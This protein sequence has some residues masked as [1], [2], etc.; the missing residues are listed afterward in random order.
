M[1]VQQVK[2]IA[3]A[4]GTKRQAAAMTNQGDER[5]NSSFLLLPRELPDQI[6]FRLPIRRSVRT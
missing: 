5:S 4:G 1:L 3:D 6:H 2:R